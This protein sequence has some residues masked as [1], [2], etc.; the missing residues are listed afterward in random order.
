MTNNPYPSKEEFLAIF[1]IFP[2]GNPMHTYETIKFHISS[3]LTFDD[4]DVT[5]KLIKTKWQEYITKN[6]TSGQKEQYIKSMQSFLDSGDYNN[7]FAPSALE[8]GG[9]MDKFAKKKTP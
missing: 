7:S 9:W 3:K 8:T 2:K 6:K 1:N 5:W 4:K